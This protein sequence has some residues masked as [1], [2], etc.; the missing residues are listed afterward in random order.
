MKTFIADKIPRI[1]KYSQKL[2]SMTLLTNQQW[3]VV[4]QITTSKNSQS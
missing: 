4:D 2:D 1:Q 3:V